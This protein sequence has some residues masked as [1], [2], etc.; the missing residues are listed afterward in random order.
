MSAEPVSERSIRVR[1]AASPDSSRGGHH[2]S[3]GASARARCGSRSTGPRSA[4][5]SGPHTVDEL[6]R[7]L[8]H[9]RQYRPTWACVLLT[10]NGR[11]RGTA[12]GRSAPAATSASGAADGY[13]YADGGEGR[14]GRSGPGRAAAHHG[15]APAD[16]VHAEGRDLRGARV[17]R[18]RRAQP[19]RGVRPDHRQPRARP[20]QA[21]RRRRG[22]L[23]RRVRLGL[24]GPPGGPEVRPGDLLPRPD[25]HRSGDVPDGGGQRGRAPRRPGNAWRW[26]GLRKSTRRA[27]R[28]SGC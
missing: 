19:A 9:A 20:V 8:D 12:D 5:P 24:P 27:P 14:D 18:R 28:R 4:T 22:Q 13:Q 26:S 11:H 2:L 6:Y 17:G 15:G 16:P 7:A 25:L 21:D 23:R 10:G 3:P 1:G